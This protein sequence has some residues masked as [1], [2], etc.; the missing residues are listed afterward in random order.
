MDKY[1]VL[2]YL[3]LGVAYNLILY[4]ILMWMGWDA[5]KHPGKIYRNRRT[6][7]FL[8]L[9]VCVFPYMGD[10]YHYYNIFVKFKGSRLGHIEDIYKYTIELACGSYYFWRLIIWGSSILL[11]TLTAKILKLNPTITWFVYLSYGLIFF[12]N[13]RV[14]LAMSIMY[15]GLAMLACGRTSFIKKLF[16]L[17]IICCS[18]FFHKSALFGIVTIVMSIICRRINRVTIILSLLLI[19][20]FIIIC[21]LFL[22]D[23]MLMSSD[24][25]SNGIVASGQGYMNRENTEYGI[26]RLLQKYLLWIDFGLWFMIIF[27]AVKTKLYSKWTWDKRIFVNYSFFTLLISTLFFFDLGASTRILQLRFAEFAFFPIAVT[28]TACRMADFE[29][30][31]TRWAVFV[32]IIQTTYN[33]IYGLYLSY[34]N[35][36]PS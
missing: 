25:E 20:V 1:I 36:I 3:P 6:Y 11:V 21:K 33:L 14:T 32:G 22:A 29:N 23:F 27:R 19:P 5:W 35:P 12:F 2:L 13:G 24:G 8:V 17:A 30:K 10:F 9:L 26:G 31:L 28:I 4:A 16:C 7:I 15:F 18:V 34:L